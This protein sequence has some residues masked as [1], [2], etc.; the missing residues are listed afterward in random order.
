MLGV[1]LSVGMSATT[2]DFGSTMERYLEKGR[3]LF[4]DKK[5]SG[6][7]VVVA[8]DQ[9]SLDR[10]NG[11]PFKRSMHGKVV[12][13]LMGM[14]ADKVIFD[15]AFDSKSQDP[16]E[17]QKLAASLQKHPG[18]IGLIAVDDT[19]N[20][21]MVALPPNENL[22]PYAEVLS[23]YIGYD[24][25][26]QIYDFPYYG[27]IEGKKHY[28][29]AAFASSTQ[30]NDIE[31]HPD[32][33]V[34]IDSIPTVSYA[35]I[36]EGKLKKDDVQGKTFIIGA[37]ATGMGD[38][39]I[40]IWDK[41]KAGVYFHA[42]AAETLKRGVPQDFGGYPPLVAI[43]FIIFL[44]SYVRNRLAATLAIFSGGLLVM[45]SSWLIQDNLM[46][47]TDIVPAESAALAAI[48][49]TGI[50][51]LAAKI[52]VTLTTNEGT[53]LP[54]L[55][56]MKIDNPEGV[57]I[58]VRLRN[59]LDT[60]AALGKEKQTELLRRA[61]DRI[62]VAAGEDQVYQ[63][64]EHSFS[65]KTK[66][67]GVE[68]LDAIEG[69]V[70]LF[71]GGIPVGGKTIDAPIS[72][73]ICEEA[74]DL[75]ASVNHALLASDSAARQG[76]P[77]TR[78]Q[79]EDVDAEWR[80]SMMSQL[81][82]AIDDGD[83]W[84]AYQPKYDLHAG[85]VV[86]AEALVRWT[87]PDRGPVRPDHFIPALEEAGRIDKLTLHVLETAIRDFAPLNGISVA[88]NLS[89]IMLGKGKIVG[90]VKGYL[91]KYGM[92]PN[93]LTLE[94]TESAAMNNGNEVEEL[95][96]LKE[97]GIKI[98]IDDYGTGQSTL[99]Y[100]KKLPATELKIDQ[101][102]VRVVL[103]SRSDQ[104]MISST[105]SLAHELGMQVVAEGVETN[106]ILEALRGLDCDIIQGYYIGKPAAF[107][108]FVTHVA[109]EIISNAA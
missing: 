68:L 31:F 20:G 36:I 75:Q 80:I 34:D 65:W 106:E 87:H 94:V 57:T 58:A 3:S 73:G 108:E 49:F 53:N 84:V 41:W 69:L 91:A 18:K 15:V 39:W 63:V 5:A 33:S 88:V 10:L 60:S 25:G 1:A 64:D 85:K 81:E 56:A 103:N 48:A 61:R 93:F 47:I 104:L 43:G 51:A 38:Q 86:G 23:G 14:G 40:T 17:D 70:A 35:D 19:V 96:E 52:M 44:A 46:V 6:D 16:R 7:V 45:F 83:V 97:M 21:K 101:S 109:K 107:D 8:I 76:L 92:N 32:W 82:K 26:T 74:A 99:N 9:T 2:T 62:K 29:L 37:T 4:L 71:A 100:L 54:N 89:T 13:D 50:A 78:H 90:A 11:W 77:W 79:A 72:V 28:S 66:L 105:V 30:S 12:N 55:T 102:F 27:Q 98:S 95:N 59:Y 67:E 22:K 24:I 42:L